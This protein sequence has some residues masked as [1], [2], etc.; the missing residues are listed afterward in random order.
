MPLIERLRKAPRELILFATVSLTVGVGYSISDSIFNNFINSKFSLSGFQRSFLELPRELPGF[1]VLFVSAMLWFLC[2][3]RLSAVSMLLGAL[4]A[5]LIGFAS[6]D[7]TV[8]VIWLFVYSMGQ[9]LYMPLAST[10]G[11]ELAH[12]G[13]TGR[14]LGQLN[15][16][17]NMATIIGSFIV[18]VGF[19]YLGFTFQHA[20]VIAVIALVLAAIFMFQMKP[21]QKHTPRVF[22]KLRK[23]YRLY[24]ALA[25]ISG[26]RRQIFITF[27]PWVLVRIFNQPTQIMATLYTIGGVIGILFQ[28]LLGRAIDHLGERLILSGEAILLVFVCLGY[29]LAPSLLPQGTA[30]YVVCVCFLLDQMLFSVSMARSTY[31]KKIARQPA[32]IQATLTA[33]VTLDHIFSIGAALLGGLIWNA[34]GFQYVFLMG[35]IIAVI[36]FFTALRIRLPQA[37][38]KTI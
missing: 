28:P 30:F 8:M 32:D 23:E 36:N 29:S 19:G 31:M 27:A 18:M 16:I 15:S 25:I 12:E 17:R 9:H 13:Q 14:R 37:D 1:L 34:F 11:M 4:G 26:A 3:R 5:G 35:V 7:Y 20:Y 10:I 24:Y 21:E 22:L 38:R 33:G 2:S 6:S